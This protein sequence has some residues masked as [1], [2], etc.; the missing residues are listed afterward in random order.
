MGDYWTQAH[1]QA[2]KPAGAPVP[3]M[4]SSTPSASC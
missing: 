4:S 3:A 1:T 2:I